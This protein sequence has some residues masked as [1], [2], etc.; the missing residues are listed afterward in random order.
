VDTSFL[1]RTGNSILSTIIYFIFQTKVH[2]TN[3][4][5]G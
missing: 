2:A 1:S 3:M 5:L 4:E